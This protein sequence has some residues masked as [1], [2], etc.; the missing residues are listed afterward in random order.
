MNKIIGL[1][2]G[3]SLLAASLGASAVVTE[4]DVL[5]KN[6]AQEVLAIVKQDKDIRAGNQKKILALVDAKVLPNFDFERMMRMA[7]GKGW[8]GA[9]PEQ[10]KTL[11][12]EF[13]NLL[14]RTYANAFTRFQDQTVEVKPIKMSSGADEVTV[15]TLILKPGAQSIAVDY[16]MEKTAEGWKVFDLTVEGASLVTTYRSTFSDQVQQAG[17]DGLIKMLADKNAANSASSKADA[18]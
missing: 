3:A 18:K 10:K 16:E 6:T 17:I 11:V 9:T 13:R 7:V 8:R 2:L 15:K 12:S 1:C 5:I 4:P 14:V